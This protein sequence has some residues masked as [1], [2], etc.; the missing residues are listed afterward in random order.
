[1]SD[2]C[3]TR[4][5]QPKAGIPHF[6]RYFQ[7]ASN[8]TREYSCQL[9][10]FQRGEI[11]ACRFHIIVRRQHIVRSNVTNT[12]PHKPR[13]PPPPSPGPDRNKP[14]PVLHL[15]HDDCRFAQPRGATHSPGDTDRVLLALW[16]RLMIH[17]LDHAMSC[18]RKRP[19]HLMLR[20]RALICG[21][22]V[23][24]LG[25]RWDYLS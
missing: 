7:V 21:V 6:S 20:L 17:Y 25:R 12:L 11:R 15:S 18:R 2:V 22:S 9:T 16:A 5:G 3:N 14:T 8:A 10:Q 19:V 24:N 1:M 4:H 23:F 13:E